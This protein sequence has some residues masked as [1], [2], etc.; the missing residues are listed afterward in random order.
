MALFV[1]STKYTYIYQDF[2]QIIVLFVLYKEIVV[3]MQKM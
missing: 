3:N 2:G 1:S